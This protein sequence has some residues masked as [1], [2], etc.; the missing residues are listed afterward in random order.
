MRD[1]LLYLSP[2]IARYCRELNVPGPSWKRV[3]HLLIILARCCVLDRVRSYPRIV[4]SFYFTVRDWRMVNIYSHRLVGTQVG[5]STSL[6][7]L[8]VRLQVIEA[9]EHVLVGERRAI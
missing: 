7:G 4:I 3:L 1:Q 8:A 5:G 2:S 9:V 6:I